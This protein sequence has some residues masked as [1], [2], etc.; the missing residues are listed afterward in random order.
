MIS[1]TIKYS[2]DFVGDLERF[3][4][5]LLGNIDDAINQISIIV[6]SRV[7]QKINQ[8]PRSGRIYRVGS[9]GHYRFHQSSA[10]GE[11]PKTDTG[12]LV[13]HTYPKHPSFL[14]SQVISDAAYSSFLELGTSKM[15]PRP[16]MQVTVDEN[17]TE[18]NKIIDAA[19][20]GSL[21]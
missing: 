7:R 3:N 11:P 9:R 16:Y 8:G 20:R 2:G 4:K 18:I 14:V 19:I 10:P 21:P 15:A 12:N 5:E 6:A 17:Q 13:S 1:I